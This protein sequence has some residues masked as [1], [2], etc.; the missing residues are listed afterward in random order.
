MRLL[1]NLLVSFA[2]CPSVISA[3]SIPGFDLAGIQLELGDRQEPTLE[4]IRAKYNTFYE[5]NQNEWNLQCKTGAGKNY[6]GSVK[7]VDKRLVF[8]SRHL[9][10]TCNG[11]TNKRSLSLAHFV[12]EVNK[13]T[14]WSQSECVTY[15]DKIRLNE[16]HLRCGRYYSL[17]AASIT[18]GEWV[19]WIFYS[20]R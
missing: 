4:L 6:V 17:T 9:G 13:V 5:P 1:F 12:G 2:V 7:F 11:T 18:E 14:G 19:G 20:K 10:T 8:A 15:G 16:I 3:Q